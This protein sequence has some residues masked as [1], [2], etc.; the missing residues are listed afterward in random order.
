MIAETITKKSA[1]YV[2]VSI[3]I[4]FNFNYLIKRY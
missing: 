1:V 2:D 3:C 4:N